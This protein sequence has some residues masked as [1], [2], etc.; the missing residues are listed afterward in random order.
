MTDNKKQIEHGSRFWNCRC[1]RKFMHR[2]DSHFWCRNCRAFAVDM[3]D[4]RIDDLETTDA[5]CICMDL[6]LFHSNEEA[7]HAHA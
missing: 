2:R 5:L 3:P 6:G 7:K 1:K 4:S